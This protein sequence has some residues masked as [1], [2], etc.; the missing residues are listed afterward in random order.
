M[1][2]SVLQEE[3]GEQPRGLDE[4]KETQ[5]CSPGS[6]V[7]GHDLLIFPSEG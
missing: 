6:G 5:A 3:E 7:H 2:H 1:G 4:I